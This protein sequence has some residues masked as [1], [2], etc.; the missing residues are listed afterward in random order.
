MRLELGNLSL[1]IGGGESEQDKGGVTTS[2]QMIVVWQYH[3]APPGEGN[4]S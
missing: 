4:C 3:S 1:N 2:C